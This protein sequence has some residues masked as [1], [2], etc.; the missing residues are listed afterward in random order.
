M[1][2]MGVRA[3]HYMG[4][5]RFYSITTYLVLS[6]EFII[7]TITETNYGAEKIRPIT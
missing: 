2:R 3:S 5:W 1:G 7:A 4:V 6:A